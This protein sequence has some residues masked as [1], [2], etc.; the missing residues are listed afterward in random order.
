MR[1]TV[2]SDDIVGE[3]YETLLE[4]PEQLSSLLCNLADFCE[5]RTASLVIN[6]MRSGWGEAAT[7]RSNPDLLEDYIAHWS[8]KDPVFAKAIMMPTGQVGG[9]SAEE[10]REFLASPLYHEMWK[11]SGLGAQRRFANLIMGDGFMVN[12]AIFANPD[13]DEFSGHTDRAYRHVLPHLTRAAA[14]AR[15]QRRLE[16]EYATSALRRG[17]DHAG[18]FV[19]S[20]EG[21]L[22]YADEA[23][24]DLLSEEP[25]L[26][27]AAG[28]LQI[29]DPEVAAQVRTALQDLRATGFALAR[30]PDCLPLK[31]KRDGRLLELEVFPCPPQVRAVFLD[32]L[33]GDTCDSVLLV[34]DPLQGRRHTIEIVKQG[35]GLTH[36]EA[37]LVV[38]MLK[39]DGR[40]AAA[41]RCG[42]AVNTARAHL[43]NVFQK[44]NIGRQAE[45]VAVIQR[46]L[47]RHI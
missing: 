1:V 6:D 2:S 47:H 8:R 38:E 20:R 4:Q 34:R 17:A 44:M 36:A 30:L 27:L 23:A 37:L 42:I 13:S 19:L 12:F 45:L 18:M 9:L 11:H 16:I 29:A 41:H 26:Q 15:K 28:R 3:I 24:E 7:P 5:A 40:E 31:S 25:Q 32:G 35:F 39:G 46:Y 43:R 14:L 22:I 21:R 10:R 33:S